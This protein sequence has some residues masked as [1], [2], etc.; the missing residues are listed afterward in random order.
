MCVTL[1]VLIVLNLNIIVHDKN[2]MLVKF[3]YLPNDAP[4][5]H[6]MIL[7]VIVQGDNNKKIKINH[8]HVL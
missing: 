8:G 1:L 2:T 5:V 4:K 3:L 7:M 6:F